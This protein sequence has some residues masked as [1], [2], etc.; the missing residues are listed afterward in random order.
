MFGCSDHW[1]G[2]RFAPALTEFLTGEHERRELRAHDAVDAGA[3]DRLYD[4]W[5]AECDGAP[6]SWWDDRDA[7]IDAS[8]GWD[9]TT[10]R[11]PLGRTPVA[12]STVETVALGVFDPK[13]EPVVTVDSG[14]V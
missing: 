10:A 8:G 1:I 5:R 9:S 2:R 12:R 11:V 7:L 3:V 14:D 4:A 6:R 13:R